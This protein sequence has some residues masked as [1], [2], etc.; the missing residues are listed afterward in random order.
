M[1]KIVT[2][3]GL[4]AAATLVLIGSAAEIASARSDGDGNRY[5]PVARRQTPTLV[6]NLATDSV[7]SE[8]E[9]MDSDMGPGS[10]LRELVERNRG[11]RK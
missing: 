7:I 3:L 10:T 9:M 5:E 11:R 8:P 1:A 2:R 6:A 4:I